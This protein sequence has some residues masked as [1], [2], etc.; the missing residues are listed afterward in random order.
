MSNEQQEPDRT[1]SSQ[2]Q[3]TRLEIENKELLQRLEHMQETAQQR[4]QADDQLQQAHKQNEILRQRLQQTALSDALF[5][6]A[7]EIGLSPSVVK[8]HSHRFSCDLDDNGQI[9]IS[10]DPKEFL[11]RLA[12]E[13]PMLKRSV[14]HHAR[15]QQ[16]SAVVTGS[17]QPEEMPDEEL[18]WM[19]D[20][21]PSRKMTFV[22]RYGVQ[23]YLQLCRKVQRKTRTHR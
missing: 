14:E 13:D 1:P 4:D 23:K 9:Q 18:L 11:T 3:L 6:A 20:R 16:L 7:Q 17:Q 10:P 12:G 21:N 22:A 19:L 5:Q 8:T 2:E 15:Q